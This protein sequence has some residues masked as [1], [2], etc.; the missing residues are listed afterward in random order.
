MEKT[1]NYDWFNRHLFAVIPPAAKR[2]LD[3]GCDTGL[4]GQALKQQDPERHVAGI[5][6]DP[7]SAKL[8]KTRMDQ[9]I[10]ANVEHDDISK[11]GGD[12]DVIILGDVVEHLV[13]PLSAL[14]KLRELLA[15][16][17]ELFTSIP[18]I[19]HYSIFRRLLKGDFQYRETGLLD[20]THLRFFCLAN[21]DKLMLDA[22]FVPR[23]VKRMVIEDT[24]LRPQLEH[25]ATRMGM[26]R[27]NFANFST[28]QYQTAARRSAIPAFREPV[29]VTFV[30]HS[31]Y[32]GILK[33]NFYASPL[34]KGDHPHQILIFNHKQCSLEE[35]WQ[36]GIAKA[37][38][39]YV[40]LVKEHMYLPK[41]WGRRLAVAID[42]MEQ[43]AGADWIA[44]GQGY[45]AGSNGLET[46][47]AIV[48]SAVKTYCEDGEPRPVDVLDDGVIVMPADNTLPIDPDLGNNLYGIDLA[49]RARAQGRAVFALG[50]PCFN[51]TPFL[52]RPSPGLKE[53]R[54]A[55]LSKRPEAGR[56]LPE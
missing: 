26:D 43:Q 36:K 47:G 41:H 53:S 33:D 39:E 12:Y 1:G 42:A 54:E 23:M 4:M 55:L 49:L 50:N 32:T 16:K 6:L 3:V 9:V 24:Q 30:V 18:N 31:Q 8:A 52:N 48:Q 25:L 35:A 28:F 27:I 22:G 38:K 11:L 51:N 46:R 17:G 21:I 56:Y 13:D 7:V 2:I 37:E 20:A 15:P 10:V 34:V 29:G 14:E 19:Q 44:G 45:L 40:V 5:E